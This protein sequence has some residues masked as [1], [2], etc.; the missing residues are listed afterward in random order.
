M[1]SA[2]DNMVLRPSVETE[3]SALRTRDDFS[4]LSSR[5]QETIVDLD[6]EDL[7]ELKHAAQLEAGLPPSHENCDPRFVLPSTSKMAGQT[8]APFLAKHIPQQYAPLGSK[9]SPTLLGGSDKKAPN[10]NTK[11][12]YRHHPDSKCRRT[13]DEPTMENLQK[14]CYWGVILIEQH[15]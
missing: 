3:V 8:V 2:A 14:V 5:G 13:A 15:L 4:Q 10:P 9:L 6:A 1:A 7:A 11:Y 12:C